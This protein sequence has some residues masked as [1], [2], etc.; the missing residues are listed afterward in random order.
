MTKMAKL[1]FKKSFLLLIVGMLLFMGNSYA[2]CTQ[3]GAVIAAG[4]NGCNVW[5]Q[6]E[7]NEVFQPVNKL[8]KLQVGQNIR[9]AYQ[10]TVGVASCSGADAI[11]ITCLEILSEDLPICRAKFEYSILPKTN[12]GFYP[13]RFVNRSYGTFE[14]VE[15]DFGNGQVKFTTK[16]TVYNYYTK[17]GLFNVCLTVSGGADCYHQSCTSLLVGDND[18]ICKDL[19]CVYPGDANKD[20]KA[21]LY[22]MLFLGLGDGY[23][24]EPRIQASLQWKPQAAANWDENTPQGLNYKH[25]DGDGNGVIQREDEAA[26]YANYTP[27]GNVTYPTV[28]GSPLLK[29]VFDEDSIFVDKNTGK[30]ALTARLELASNDKQIPV[31]GI[32]AYLKYPKEYVKD[33]IIHYPQPS[34][35]GEEEDVIWSFNDMPEQSQVDLAVARIG[36][37]GV[38]A[39]GPIAIVT[40]IVEADIIMRAQH[41]NGQGFEVE[42][43][44]GMMIDDVGTPYSI[45]NEGKPTKVAVVDAEMMAA[46]TKISPEATAAVFPNPAKN[47]VKILLPSGTISKV[48]LLNPLGGFIAAYHADNEQYITLDVSDLYP[49]VYLCKIQTD[50]GAIIRNLAIK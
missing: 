25:F 31:Y 19:D 16:D 23:T 50:K 21:N 18:L 49:G 41:G 47:S 42:V 2:Q 17:V 24:G 46:L 32:A 5:I 36:G 1:T 4:K 35:L 34:I 7:T 38:T 43:G 44:G 8:D 12:D 37:K 22:D 48:E 40:Y 11:K 39:T 10:N 9:F 29:L 33:I 45:T 28:S 3:K 13:V 6:S 27:C 20:G 26:I 15:W 14:N 30:M